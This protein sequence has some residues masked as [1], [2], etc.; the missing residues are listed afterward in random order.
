MDNILNKNWKQ[1]IYFYR[2]IEYLLILKRYSAHSA[3]GILLLTFAGW[4]CKLWRTIAVISPQN[5]HQRGSNNRRFP[6]DSSFSLCTY[7]SPCSSFLVSFSSS[8]SYLISSLLLIFIFFLSRT[9]PMHGWSD[10]WLP[11]CLLFFFL[12][13]L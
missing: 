4:T 6:Q 11:H 1:T 5:C 7:S 2:V 8:Y 10:H 3:S 13:C 12:L 9:P